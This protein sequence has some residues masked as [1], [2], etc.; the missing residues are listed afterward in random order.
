VHDLEDSSEAHVHDLNNC[1]RFHKLDDLIY[2][3]HALLLLGLGFINLV[4][5]VAQLDALQYQ[6]PS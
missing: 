2:Y 4:L 1:F 6:L 3:L 5:E